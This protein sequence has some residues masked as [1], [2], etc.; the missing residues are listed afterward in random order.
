MLLAALRY[1]VLVF[2]LGFLL[3]SVREL[4]TGPVLGAF[5]AL[6]LE[7]PVM[8]LASVIVARQTL[9]MYKVESLLAAVGVGLLAFLMLIVADGALA[10]LLEQR[11]PQRWLASQLRWPQVIGFGGQVAFAVIPALLGLARKLHIRL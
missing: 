7:V 6:T 10:W 8:V 5:W 3:G 9:A 11:L 2:A 4:A 1:F